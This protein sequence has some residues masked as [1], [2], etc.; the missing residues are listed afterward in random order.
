M[1]KGSLTGIGI[2]PGDPELITLKGYKVLQSA[3]LIFY[4]A[5]SRTANS[6][7]SFSSA[8]LEPLQLEAPCRPLLFPMTGKNRDE[9]YREAYFEVK[10]EVE[11]GKKVVVVSEGDLLFYSTFGYLLQLATADNLSCTLIPGIPA[12]IAAGSKGQQPIVDGKASLQVFAAIRSFEELDG[13]LESETTLVIMKPSTVKASWYDF[14]KKLNRPFLYA[15][16]VG[17]SDEFSTLNIEELNGR[18]IPY[19]SILLIYSNKK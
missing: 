16:R 12:F 10:A 2:G 15:E 7:K 5:S 17:T 1:N 19:F 9:F 11:A 8:I 13:A 3:D 14:L 18:T 4:P 6:V